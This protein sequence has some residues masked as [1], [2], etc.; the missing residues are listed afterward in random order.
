M[1][2]RSIERQWVRPRSADN[3]SKALHKVNVWPECDVIPLFNLKALLTVATHFFL[4]LPLHQVLA[5]RVWLQDLLQINEPLD[6]CLGRFLSH[7]GCHHSYAPECAG[8]WNSELETSGWITFGYPKWDRDGLCHWK[9]MNCQAMVPC[10][11]FC[12]THPNL[13]L[14]L[15][16]RKWTRWSFVSSV[17]LISSQIISKFS[18]C[19]VFVF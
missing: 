10:A 7:H 19:L 8:Q 2:W 14:C 4:R 16:I 12:W 3:C 17:N 1:S 13:C 15:A 5:G 6:T 9:M 11:A 18:R